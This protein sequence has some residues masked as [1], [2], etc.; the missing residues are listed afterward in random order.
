VQKKI[1]FLI[2]AIT[3][4][5]I[6][7]TVGI[8]KRK[9]VT[10]LNVKKGDVLEAIYGL[11]KVKSRH[12]FEVKIG[13]MTNVEKVYVREGDNVAK[14]DKII[15]FSGSGLFKAPF[16]G[17]VTLVEL[18]KGEI[19]LPQIPIV[20][21]ENLEDKYIEVS[22]EQDAALKV[23]KGQK[24]QVVFENL[25]AEK[26]FGEVKSIY[27]KKGEFI[28]HIDL[29]NLPGNILPGMTADVVIEVGKKQGVMLI[30]VKAI[31]EGRVVRFRDEKKKVIEVEIGKSDGIWAELSQ[32]DIKESDKLI[33]KGKQ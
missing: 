12:S 2:G 20:R 31:T 7:T 23:K 16:A 10:L 4:I 6:A 5:S 21:L 8:Y 3:I 13:V 24:A 18:K 27:P 1:L 17:T 9:N 29:E 14:G 28:A 22:L 33:I 25:K 11:G 19:A 26:L 15:S 30:P 32:G